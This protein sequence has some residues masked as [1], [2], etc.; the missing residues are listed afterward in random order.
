[1]DLDKGGIDDLAIPDGVI[2]DGSQL[3]T[4]GISA[5]GQHAEILD[6]KARVVALTHRIRSFTTLPYVFTTLRRARRFLG[7]DADS[8]TYYLVRLLPG[9]VVG[10]VRATL[11]GKL[12]KA[13][14]LTPA[15][16]HKRSLAHWLYHTGAGGALLGGA[17]LGTIVGTMVMA[18]TLYA[19][20]KEHID[21][22]ATLRAFGASALYINRVILCQGILSAVIGF[23]I[24]ALLSLIIVWATVDAA[25][26]VVMTPMLTSALFA[27]TVI[28]CVVSCGSA[29][30]QVIRVDP[31]RV[32]TR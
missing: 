16:F 31:V 18:Q 28:M 29:I 1:M 25:V 2:I 5:V 17:I 24:A 7:T 8:S 30:I 6:A 22:F 32:F 14:V 27:L 20:T 11:A 21:E 9:S 13:E 15:E 23:A 3:D 12:S 4:L 26:P 10:Q 19:S